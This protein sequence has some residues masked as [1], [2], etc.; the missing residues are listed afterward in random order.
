MSG[1]LIDA[2]FLL[3]F[4]YGR[5]K[6]NEEDISFLIAG[7]EGTNDAT[8]VLIYTIIDKLATSD[9][10]L[11]EANGRVCIPY[12][13]VINILHPLM[14]PPR[15]E[16][17]TEGEKEN[18]TT[19]KDSGFPFKNTSHI[20]FPDGRVLIKTRELHKNKGMNADARN[21]L[22]DEVTE[23]VLNLPYYEIHDRRLVGVETI[24]HIID[25]F[26]KPK[27]VP[28]YRN[29]F[30]DEILC[31]LRAMKDP[32]NY[33]KL[34]DEIRSFKAPEPKPEPETWEN[35]ISETVKGMKQTVAGD[36]PWPAVAF[37]LM[38]CIEVLAKHIKEMECR[39]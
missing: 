5:K 30:I 13:E 16:L 32:F 7:I 27:P 31:K 6:L 18:V 36:H 22:L 23:K 2:E 34:M 25:S 20:T 15:P 4:L 39:E 21:A 24:K 11:Y 33:G 19:Q 3:N 38:Y 14:N 28:E 9:D 8:N 37:S 10:P 1:K 29:E 35:E 26:K 12:L 17:N